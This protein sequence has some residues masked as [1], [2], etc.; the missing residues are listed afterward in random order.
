MDNA[1]R[2]AEI[3]VGTEIPPFSNQVGYMELNQFAGANREWGL[4]HMDRAH[5]Q[6]E[7]LKDVIIMGN[8][9]MAYV[10]NML[11]DWVGE[12]AWIQK[13]ATSYRGLDYVHDTLTSRGR[14]TNRFVHDG[15]TYVECEIWVENQRGE[16]GTTGSATIVLPE[17]SL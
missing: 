4:Y 7:G 13:I 1:S 11:E 12:E 9:K 16:K 14:V 17:S 2:W 10:G 6:G 5:A 15:R 3:E 8:L